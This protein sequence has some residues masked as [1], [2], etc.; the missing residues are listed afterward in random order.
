MRD[1]VAIRSRFP[2]LCRMHDG[3]VVVFADAPGGSQCP[4]WL[5]GAVS[6][7]RARGVSNEHG[8]FSTSRETDELILAGREA[9]AD[10]VGADPSEIVFGPNPTSLLFAISRSVS[11]TLG[12]N[13]EV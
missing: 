10:L 6:G 9:A 13:D 7:H 12:P 3:R 8:A 11:R 4:D 5:I 1:V 2:A